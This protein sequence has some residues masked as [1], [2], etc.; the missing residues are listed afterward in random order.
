MLWGKPGDAARLGV[1]ATTSSM[2]ALTEAIIAGVETLGTYKIGEWILEQ[3]DEF[4]AATQSIVAH[5]GAIGNELATLPA[6]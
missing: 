5:A 4:Q 1:Q 2:D 6:R 3:A